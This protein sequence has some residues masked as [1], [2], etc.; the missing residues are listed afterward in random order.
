M[1]DLVVASLKLL[2]FIALVVSH[3]LRGPGRSSSHRLRQPPTREPGQ[4]AERVRVVMFTA[5][6]CGPCQQFKQQEIPKLTAAGYSSGNQS[7]ADIEFMDYERS[8][9]EF[10]RLQLR[11]LPAFVFVKGRNVVS[12]MQ[13]YRSAGQIQAELNRVAK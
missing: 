9:S 11:L 1:P 3:D 10:N 6:W 12:K 13:G 7:A 8:R 5:H 4:P 2:L